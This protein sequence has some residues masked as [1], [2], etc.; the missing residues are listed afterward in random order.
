[1]A[2]KLRTLINRISGMKLRYRMLFIYIIGGAV[3]IT[4][5]GLYLVHGMSSILIEQ[6][7]DAEVI[8]LEMARR[9][10]EE[11]TGTVSTVTK[12]FYFNPQLEEIASK[13]YED[14]QEVV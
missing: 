11:M 5:I 7:K 8:E 9:Q 12:Y 4:F 14:Y 2:Q 13:K 10:V 6:A 1:M 3:P